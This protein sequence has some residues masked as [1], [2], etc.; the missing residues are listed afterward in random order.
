M[1]HAPVAR[2]SATHDSLILAIPAPEIYTAK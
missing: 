1:K 2:C